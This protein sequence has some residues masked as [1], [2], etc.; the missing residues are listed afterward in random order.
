[1][2]HVLLVDD[3]ADLRDVVA[4]MLEVHGHR[5]EICDSAEAALEALQAKLPDAIILDQRLPGMN[6]VE[7]VKALRNNP[8]TAELQ[9]IV[10]SADDSQAAAAKAAGASDFWLK[11]SD[12]L[13]EGIEGLGR[14]L[15]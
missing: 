14:E 15:S 1:M 13:F 2:A 10:Y 4:Q 6:G 3:H 9:V 11:G 7:L 5:V 12:G 8:R